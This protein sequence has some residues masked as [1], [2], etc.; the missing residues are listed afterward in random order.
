MS[1]IRDTLRI[2][3]PLIFVCWIVAAVRL[4]VEARTKDVNVVAMVSVY[5]TV[6]VVFLF[7]GFTG[8]FDRLRW[9]GLFI[10]PLVLGIA[11]WTVP[12]F[13]AYSIGQ[14]AGWNH[15]RFLVDAE[16]YA[17][18][19][20]LIEGGMSIFEAKAKSEEILKREDPSRTAPIA[21]TS[22]G[23]ILTAL[24]VAGFT[25]I[26]GVVWSLVFGLLLVG[27]PATVRSRRSS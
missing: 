1:L 26:G 4:V 13:I 7:A 20:P 23:K 11:C 5:A 19:K 12:N 9:K 17:I 6:F 2:L 25:T 21:P 3:K 15:G 24:S 27:I 16:H 14:F 8:Q 10:A 18:Q 22:A